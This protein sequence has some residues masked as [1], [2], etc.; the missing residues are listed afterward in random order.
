MHIANRS[1]SPY[2]TLTEPK[3]PPE[4]EC[5]PINPGV[6]QKRAIDSRSPA[7]QELVPQVR[8]LD[9]S[10]ESGFETVSVNPDPDKRLGPGEKIPL[11]TN[12]GRNFN[13]EL[14]TQEITDSFNSVEQE[15][16]QFLRKL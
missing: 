6:R 16:A 8:L 5:D 11:Q 9:G 4:N 7:Y 14:A 10:P 13:I 2:P 15:A 12:L 1:V 3:L